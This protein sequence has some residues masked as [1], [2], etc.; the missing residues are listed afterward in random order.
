MKLSYFV[1]VILSSSL[2]TST[3]FAGA[4]FNIAPDSDYPWP[5][6][7]YPG[8]MV[9][10]YYQITNQTSSTRSGYQIQGLPSTVTQDFSEGDCQQSI[11]LASQASCIL[12][13]NIT[14]PTQSNFALCHGSNCT[15]ASVPLSISQAD[16]PVS[17]AYVADAR[18]FENPP[19]AA[20]VFQCHLNS[21]GG[22]EFCAATPSSDAPNWQP[23]SISFATVNA[24]KYAYVSDSNNLQIHQCQVDSD[25]AFSAC[26]LVSADTGSP[27]NFASFSGTQYAYLVNAGVLNQCQ[28]N[29]SD[30][31][32]GSCEATPSSNVPGSWQSVLSLN[33]AT[34]NNTPYAYVIATT[35]FFLSKVF[36]CAVDEQ[37]GD[38]IG[39]T[40][41]DITDNSMSLPLSLS[42]TTVN[43]NQY[44]YV[45]SLFSGLSVCG[46]NSNNGSFTACT[47]LSETRP[48][49][50]SFKTINNTQYAY[51]AG[52]DGVSQCSLN[53]DGSFGSCALTPAENSVWS[54]AINA[55][56][57]SS[58]N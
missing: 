41:Q 1:S 3:A 32:F 57:F 58:G 56:V 19:Y 23:S 15:K 51:V 47:S 39:S 4:S 54:G 26:G 43:N 18:D 42:S 14:G 30:G 36:Q 2:L 6:S 7:V 31:S 8:Q 21:S 22:L 28:L 46:L 11:S 9:H 24:I 13:L 53:S 49:Q 25:G 52:Q 38:L 48:Y 12:K 34:V 5:S 50:M 44:A 10:A 29:N 20:G 35:G 27:V 55:V 40:C 37:T 16:T 33:F 17:Y 45:G